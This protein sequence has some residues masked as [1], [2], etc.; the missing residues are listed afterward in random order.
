MEK[1]IRIHGIHTARFLFYVIIALLLF[2]IPCTLANV[3]DFVEIKFIMITVTALFAVPGTALFGFALYWYLFTLEVSPT[4]VIFSAPLRKAVILTREEITA[5]GLISYYGQRDIRL[6]VCEADRETVWAFFRQNPEKC[7]IFFG[8][9]DYYKL[10]ETEE[11]SWTMA[12]GV[13]IFC[14]Q[15]SV[16]L[17]PHGNVKSMKT[18]ERIINMKPTL[19]GSGCASLWSSTAGEFQ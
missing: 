14:R 16:Y 6:Y 7:K 10:L 9:K 2:L 19:T 3:P 15:P 1:K 17:L 8:E 12:M 4:Q 18:M 5:F 13:Y 11:K